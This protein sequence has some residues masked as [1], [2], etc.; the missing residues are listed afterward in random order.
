MTKTTDRARLA[1]PEGEAVSVRVL[2]QGAGRIF[3]GEANDTAAEPHLRF[4]TYE[5]GEMFVAA[6]D[7]AAALEERGLVEI[8]P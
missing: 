2:P 7:I 5:R 6:P 4:A 8:Q 3:T 1:A